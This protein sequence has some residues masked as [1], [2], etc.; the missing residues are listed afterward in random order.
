MPCDSFSRWGPAD[1]SPGEAGGPGAAT[2]AGAAGSVSKYRE[3][4][5]N[6]AVPLGVDALVGGLRLDLLGKRTP[7][8]GR[9][10]SLPAGLLDQGLGP[11]PEIIAGRVDDP[12]EL[13]TDS[14]L[15]EDGMSSPQLLVKLACDLVT[16]SGG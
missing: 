9:K 5:Q 4:A 10:A 11:K 13:A 8:L 2:R 14:H 12:Q 7:K 16:R 6:R 3:N 1:G 15:V